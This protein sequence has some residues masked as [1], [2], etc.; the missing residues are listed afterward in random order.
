MAV[1]E[2]LEIRSAP[3]L[4]R[5]KHHHCKNRGHCPSSSSRPRGEIDREECCNAGTS[6]CI[7]RHRQA[8]KIDHVRRDM[9][10][11]ADD[12]R[13]RCGLV[14]S[15]ILVER[16]DVVEWSAPEERYEVTAD[17]EEDKYNVHV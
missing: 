2:M 17:G 10:G 1:P 9:N 8:V 12:N 7:V 16:N 15:N 11:C 6:G 14:E 13:P 4:H 5:K 3:L